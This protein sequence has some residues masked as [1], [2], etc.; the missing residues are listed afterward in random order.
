METHQIGHYP[1]EEV[2]TC[3]GAPADVG[4]GIQLL[5]LARTP[6]RLEL[7]LM[8]Q[9]VEQLLR[10]LEALVRITFVER[11]AIAPAFT[12]ASRSRSVARY[13][14]ACATCWEIV[15]SRTSRPAATFVARTRIASVARNAFGNHEPRFALS[16][17]VRPAIDAAAVCQACLPVSITK[18]AR[19]RHT[20]GAHRVALVR[21]GGRPDLLR[22]RTARA[23]RLRAAAAEVGRKLGGRLGDPRKHRNTCAS[24]LRV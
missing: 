21:H 7:G 22:S 8:G 20:L 6:E 19:T 16:S 15:S 23:A 1:I 10:T 24:S 2:I 17:S 5:A 4:R 3:C 9:A 13:G 14:I 12:P 18:R 11:L